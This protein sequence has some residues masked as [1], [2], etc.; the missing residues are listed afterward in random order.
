MQIN[1]LVEPMNGQGFRATGAQPFALSAEGATREEALKKLQEE[2]CNRLKNGAEV[3]ALEVTADEHPLL[4]YAGMF[5]DDPRI[6]EW[7]QCMAE[8]RD[9][10]E[11]DDDYR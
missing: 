1:V 4:K 9:Q 10:V 6:E 5:K 11:K 3:V 7:K 2:V 8:Y